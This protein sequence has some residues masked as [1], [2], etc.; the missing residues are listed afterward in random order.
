MIARFV[1]RN[2]KVVVLFL[3]IVAMLL[4]APEEEMKFIYTEF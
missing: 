4:L 3:V 2:W 1:R